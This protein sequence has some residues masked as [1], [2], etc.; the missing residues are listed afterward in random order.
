MLSICRSLSDVRPIT[1][2]PGARSL[3]A[4]TRPLIDSTRRPDRQLQL[5]RRLS[6]ERRAQLR[7]RPRR[8][9]DPLQLVDR[10][11]QLGRRD[12]VSCPC[13]NAAIIAVSHS[14]LMRRGMPPV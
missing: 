7:R 4:T 6:F 13:A 11:V 1:Q 2:R 9:L 10:L 14:V 5:R 12:R 8:E 3:S